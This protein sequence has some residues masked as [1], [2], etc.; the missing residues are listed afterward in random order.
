M[1][2]VEMSNNEE[3]RDAPFISP[4]S[5]T[6]ILTSTDISLLQ[7]LFQASIQHILPVISQIFHPNVL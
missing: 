1:R 5:K 7:V 2:P 4:I 3:P 6:N